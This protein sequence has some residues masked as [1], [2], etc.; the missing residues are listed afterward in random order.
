[1]HNKTE[2]QKPGLIQPYLKKIGLD[3][4]DLSNYRPVMNLTHLSKIIERTMLD[5][6]VT[7]LKEVG[8]V[9]RYQSA[10]RK[11]LST[12]TALCKIHDDL[13]SNTCHGKASLLVLLDLSTAFDTVDHLLSDFSDSGVEGTALSLLES[14][15]EN[16]EQCVAIG[17]SRTEPTTLQ[18]GVPQGSVLG[19]V[20]FTVYTGTLAFLLEAHG[21]SYHFFADDTQLYIKVEDIDEAKHRLSFLLSDL[22][23]WM[24]RRKLK[25]NDGKTEIIVT[26]GNLRNVSVANFGDISFGDTQLVPCES[27]KNLGVVLNSS[28]S[29]RS[30]IDSIVK[31]CN[32]HIR[33]LYM[34]KA[35]VN[36][37]NL[38]T[39][40]HSL[41]VSK[42]DYCNSF[43]IGLPNVIL[44]KVQFVLNRAARL[45]FNLPPRVP[46][47]SSLIKL[48]WL[49]LKQTWGR[50]RLRLHEAMVCSDRILTCRIKSIRSPAKVGTGCYRFKYQPGSMLEGVGDT[51]PPPPPQHRGSAV[52]L[53][54][55]TAE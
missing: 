16:R 7:F 47:T 12:E 55:T 23:I 20:L 19:P 2:W 45:I 27:A 21:V 36:R 33:N 6:L 50:S 53:C 48:H 46:T 26:R 44:K 41:I 15:L 25:L 5:Q 43:F 35:F 34:I 39:L 54:S 28:L 14:Y 24:A 29:F 17:E 11:V 37:K 30:H 9:P 1:M 22:K 4:N 13:V 51:P 52:I 49:P 38:A 18:Y 8:R 42:V 3:L 10:Y 40:V 32:F 31:T